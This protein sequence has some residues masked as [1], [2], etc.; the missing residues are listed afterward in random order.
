MCFD[1][2]ILA[3]VLLG[4]VFSCSPYRKIQKIKNGDTVSVRGF[5]RFVFTGVL[6]ETR[7]GKLRA[8]VEVF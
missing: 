8:K 6:Q 3:L 2:K 7:K 5:G 1:S 4:L